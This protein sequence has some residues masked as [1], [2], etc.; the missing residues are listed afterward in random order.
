MTRRSAFRLAPVCALVLIS[1]V[2]EAGRAVAG[3]P[4]TAS[5]VCP[6]CPAGPAI[7]AGLQAL[8]RGDYRRAFDDFKRAADVAPGAAEPL[9]YPVFGRWWQSFFAEGPGSRPDA[10]FDQA[11][12]VARDTASAR[13]DENKGDVGAL[14]ALGGAEVLKAHVEALRGNYWTSG[15]EARRGKKALE[16][17][18]AKDPDAGA[19][20]FPLGALNYF[21]DRVPLVVRGLRVLFFI[22][23]GNARVGLTQIRKVAE[24]DGT[25]RHEGR[26]LLALVCA[27][28]YQRAY[29]DA[30]GHFDQALRE[31]GGSAL[32]RAAIGDLQIRLGRSADA[33]A[34]LTAGI[35]ESLPDG[36]EGA[37]QRHWLRLGIV[38]AH[39]SDWRQAEAE[40]AW[41]LAQAEPGPASDALRKTEARIGGE[42]AA[43]RKALP[44]WNGDEADRVAGSAARD[45]LDRTIDAESGAPI[46]RLLRARLALDEAAPALA[47][48][49]LQ[50]AVAAISS[51]TPA[52]LHGSLHLT[53]GRALGATGDARGARTHLERAAAVRRFR[54]A[55]QARLLLGTKG[56]DAGLC[57]R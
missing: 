37:R 14:A 57:A 24:S 9:F 17:A 51:E 41:T 27:D 7:S 49:L 2:G 32:L 45:A 15:Q 22:P 33:V 1:A 52:W 34:T 5:V 35:E 54:M 50:P 38:E 19:A 43:R 53:L 56:E 25:L 4:A 6:A 48:T 31:S 10:A 18:L 39:L 42:M 16:Q 46:A 11:F 21:A 30:L 55:E 36:P 29:D 3:T 20:L 8:R 23:G 28:R 12:E 26:L 13:L 47:V 44:F 40:Q